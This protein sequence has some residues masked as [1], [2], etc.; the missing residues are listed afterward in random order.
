MQLGE[1]V[2]RV[3]TGLSG[4]GMSRVAE[5]AL[6]TCRLDVPALTVV[7]VWRSEALPTHPDKLDIPVGRPDLD[8]PPRGIVARICVFPPDSTA[9]QGMTDKD[10]QAHLSA[11]GGDDSYRPSQ[12]R[13][14]G[15]VVMHQ[16]PSVDIVYVVSGE[17][18]AVLEEEETALKQGD[19]FIQRRTNHAWSN[20]GAEPAVL[21]VVLI[22]AS[23]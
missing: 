14:S 12:V 11:I 3:I 18:F 19:V 15:R 17:I 21:F 6:A 4:H 22:G 13:G 1:D 16:T 5:D 2:R 9:R 23:V 20:R 7:D 8:P 10:A